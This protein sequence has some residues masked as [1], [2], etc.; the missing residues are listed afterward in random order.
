MQEGDP[1]H[2]PCSD[3]EEE[4]GGDIEFESADPREPLPLDIKE[5]VDS[6]DTRHGFLHNVARSIDDFAT[7][8]KDA[9]ESRSKERRVLQMFLEQNECGKERI[10]I[11]QQLVNVLA[12]PETTEMGGKE[13]PYQEGHRSPGAMIQD[14]LMV[15]IELLLKYKSYRPPSMDEKTYQR[16]LKLKNRFLGY[17]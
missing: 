12:L 11:V 14:D 3:D 15:P 1:I 7:E 4:E 6:I 5:F 8:L 13:L 2:E 17:K 16:L 9:N 10:Q